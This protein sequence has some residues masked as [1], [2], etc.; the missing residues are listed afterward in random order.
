MNE[1]IKESEANVKRA[2]AVGGGVVTTVR[3]RG[4]GSTAGCLRQR[5]AATPSELPAPNFQHK[6]APIFHPSI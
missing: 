4:C 2:A 1:Q 3:Q 5:H 6:L